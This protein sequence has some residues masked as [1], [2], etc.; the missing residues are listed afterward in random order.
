MP[1][2]QGPHFHK[3]IQAL[4]T[5][6]CSVPLPEDALSVIRQLMLRYH[7]DRHMVSRHLQEHHG[8]R[9]NLV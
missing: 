7:G 8:L 6:P 3:G 9:I 5:T 4:K 1:K 2:L